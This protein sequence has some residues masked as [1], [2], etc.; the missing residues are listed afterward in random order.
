MAKSC[1]LTV[2]QNEVKVHNKNMILLYSGTSLTRTLWDQ[3]VFEL[4]KCSSYR[5]N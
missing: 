4:V 1:N 2:G 5:M 3:R